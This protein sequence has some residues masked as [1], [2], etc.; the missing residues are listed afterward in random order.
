MRGGILMIVAAAAMGCGG[1]A[2]P[3]ETET[4]AALTAES[5]IELRFGETLAVE[6]TV[7]R[8]SF[9]DVLGD[10][11][12]PSDVTCVWAGNASVQVGISAGSGPT[13]PLVLNSTLEPRH[14]DWNGVRVTLL[15]VL[16]EPL[17]TE[18]LIP[19]DYSIRVRLTEVVPTASSS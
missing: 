12:C 14:A 5:G 19:Q 8:I 13:F 17:S 10:S 7:L 3:T 15:E 6:G 11:R 4:S 9:T 1:G 16:P 2:G 18:V